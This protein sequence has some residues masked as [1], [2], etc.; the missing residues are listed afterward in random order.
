MT[1]E[2][3]NG[4]S[5]VP[6][7]WGCLPVQRGLAE[8]CRKNQSDQT[9]HT[10]PFLTSSPHL[11][12]S[13]PC[14]LLGSHSGQARAGTGPNG[15]QPKDA[16]P[17]G[18]RPYTSSKAAFPTP[19]PTRQSGVLLPAPCNPKRTCLRFPNKS[20]VPQSQDHHADLMLGGHLLETSKVLSGH[21]S[22]LPAEVPGCHLEPQPRKLNTLGWAP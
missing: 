15:T 5:G 1:E 7:V 9:S 22:P 20:L 11:I 8:L 13:G 12:V 2:R 16:L 4:T 17:R 14:C 21:T 18:P 19:A 3:V 10:N 6:R